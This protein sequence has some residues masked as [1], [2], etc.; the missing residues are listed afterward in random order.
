MLVRANFVFRGPRDCTFFVFGGWTGHIRLYTVHEARRKLRLGQAGRK[1]IGD[2]FFVFL[3]CLCRFA[4]DEEVVV[5]ARFITKYAMNGAWTCL[6][7][8]GIFFYLNMLV[9][10]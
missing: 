9:S 8:Q 3:L 7:S 1:K 10:V 6:T 2:R 5:P 4:S